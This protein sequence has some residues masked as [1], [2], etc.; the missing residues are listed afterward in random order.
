MAEELDE[1]RGLDQ[2]LVGLPG[3]LSEAVHDLRLRGLATDGDVV[4]EGVLSHA[5]GQQL[6][7][8]HRGDVVSV[9]LGDAL[10]LLGD[11]HL[12]LDG[13]LR[14]RI[15]EAV[16][17]A[18]A[19]GDGAA[20][21]MEEDDADA[22]LLADGGEVLLGAVEVPERGEDAAVLIGVGIT[23][24]H[25]LGEAVGDTGV[26]AGLQRA[27]GHRMRQERVHDTGTP[28]KVADG[29]EERNDREETVGIFRTASGQASFTG[30]EVDG[31]QV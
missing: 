22:V 13:T 26:A 24:H 28:L 2:R 11:A 8:V 27:F 6:E 1:A 30:K 20:T 23:D 31:Q 15:D 14:E 21:A 7:V 9:L 25:L 17:R 4:Q 29:L 16:G 5:R 3:E 19:A 10:T 12:A 18:S